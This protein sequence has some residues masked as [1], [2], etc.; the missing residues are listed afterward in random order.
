MQRLTGD[1]NSHFFAV[2]SNL[3]Q[4]PYSRTLGF[5]KNEFEINVFVYLIGKI[6]KNIELIKIPLEYENITTSD[7]KG[8][9]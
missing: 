3:Y 6:S 8:I 9:N 2:S 4:N 7:I 1:F 5:T